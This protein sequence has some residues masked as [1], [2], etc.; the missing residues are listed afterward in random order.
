MSSTFAPGSSWTT[1]KAILLLQAAER[2]H[3]PGC[4]GSVT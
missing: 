2:A 3:A 1:G 4:R